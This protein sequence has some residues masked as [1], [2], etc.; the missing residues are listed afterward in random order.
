MRKVA[1]LLIILLGILPLPASAKKYGMK[2]IPNVQLGDANRLLSNPDGIISDSAEHRINAM[3]V[4]IRSKT[5]AEVAV[6]VVGNIK[7]EDID[8]F[9]TDLFKRWGIGRKDGD[10]GV[11][12]LVA[13]KMR[14]MCIRTGYGVE[15][16]LPD[17]TCGHIIRDIMTPQFRNLN[18]DKGIEEAVARIHGLLTNPEAAEE[19]AG[20]L[21]EE[22]A[23][24]ERDAL[25]GVGIFL[26]GI[27]AIAGG[28][29]GYSI[30]RRRKP[31]KCPRC[32]TTM[33]RLGEEEDNRYL[34]RQQ[35]FEEQILSNDY[36][37]WI[38]PGCGETLTLRY[39]GQKSSFYT[40]CPHCKTRAL[41]VDL[42]VIVTPATRSHPGLREQHCVCL[43]CGQK[44]VKRIVLPRI[45]SVDSSSGFGGGSMGGSFGGGST[46]GGGASGRW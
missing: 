31:R 40:N 18:Y 8:E 24:Q 12:L 10:N 19:L 25:K 14:E 43:H 38:C 28:A 3:L 35:D 34:N 15:G 23:A 27:I 37:V 17:I 16:I 29:V 46:G 4:D 30:Y 2:D 26:L 32:G 1:A 36:D 20:R 33:Q 44:T 9:A 22:E 11:L 21:R 42:S 5:T 7:S 41:K 45:T 39:N 6:V 13:V